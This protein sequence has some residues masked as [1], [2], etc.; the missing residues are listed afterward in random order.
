MGYNDNAG[1]IFVPK[2]H[3]LTDDLRLGR[4]VQGRSRFIGQQKLRLIGHAHGNAYALTLTAGKLERIGTHHAVPVRQ[5]H[6]LD[7]FHTLRPGILPGYVLMGQD[8]FYITVA[9]Q[10]G[11]VHHGAAVL[12]NHGHV[13]TPQ[14]TPL[15]GCQ[16]Q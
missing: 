10:S 8:V 5:T 12:E 16:F 1:T 9:D 4:H 2:L 7:H 14:L 15:F 3:E 6:P 13:M 11:L